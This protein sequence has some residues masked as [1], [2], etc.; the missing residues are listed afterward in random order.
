MNK[1]IKI[2]GVAGISILLGCHGSSDG[3][4]SNNKINILSPPSDNKTVPSKNLTLEIDSANIDQ[5]EV[6]N[7]SLGDSTTYQGV[8]NN[9]SFFVYRV[10]LLDGQNE[11]EVTAT[12]G[13]KTLIKKIN[14]TSTSGTE[15]R[16][17]ALTRDGYGQANAT[18]KTIYDTASVSSYLYDFDIDGIIDK[19][20]GE[21]QASRVFVGEGFY[22]ARVTIRTTDNIL[23]TSKQSE[24]VIIKPEAIE[25]DIASLQSVDVIDYQR[26]GKTDVFALT[27]DRRVLRV[28]MA[29]D[30]LVEEIALSS[31]SAPSGFC[32]DNDGNLL[33]V[34]AGQNIV[35]KLLKASFWT[36]DTLISPTG[37][38]G[39]AGVGNGQFN[40]P[41]DCMVSS[42]GNNQRIYVVDSGNNR[43]QVFN[44]AGVYLF[45]FDGSDSA[46]GKFNN[47]VGIIANV[48]IPTITD[49][50]NNLVR[51]FYGNGVQKRSF[52]GDILNQP[53]K[54]TSSDNRVIVADS[55]NNRIAFMT[56]SG[57][58][59]STLPTSQSP[60][61]AT[62]LM[63]GKDI[64]YMAPMGQGAR[65]LTAESDPSEAMPVNVVKKF[66]EAILN[67][68]KDL[69]REMS[70]GE[71]VI[72][73]IF[74]DPAKL[75]VLTAHLKITESYTLSGNNGLFS[76]VSISFLGTSDILNIG[77]MKYQGRWL[78]KAI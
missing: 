42:S 13:G 48:S 40:N 12:S 37:G 1:L 29:K 67:N 9:S 57:V 50:G 10:E 64:I 62:S 76:G 15:V 59:L 54:I 35:V 68:N 60:E 5:V 30:S 75:D 8:Q 14:V 74:N 49:S 19:T 17:S 55:A 53:K 43:V 20:T 58:L 26:V 72:T 61:V 24:P 28:D 77:L 39:G 33:I 65:K 69:L 18:F 6:K 70:V 16:L 73:R 66:V 41:S 7:N 71:Q 46:N 44:R 47:P 21:S 45:Q 36:P 52:G 27:S 78:I 4:G 11:L 2:L 3:G 31:V 63:R 38:F 25:E 51:V 23:L 34:D 32:L 22:Q 56:N